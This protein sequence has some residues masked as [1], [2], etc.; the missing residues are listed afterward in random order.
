MLSIRA[1]WGLAEKG[2]VV[3][4]LLAVFMFLCVYVPLKCQSIVSCPLEILPALITEKTPA[5]LV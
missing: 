5:Y 4:E 1:I 2:A 3:L